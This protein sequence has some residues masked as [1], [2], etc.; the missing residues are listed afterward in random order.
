MQ[1]TLAGVARYFVGP[2]TWALPV[3][4]TG[5][6]AL[7]P[8]GDDTIHPVRITARVGRPFRAGAL[9]RVANGD[10]RLLMDIVG[11]AIA[12]ALPPDYQGRYADTVPDL[13]E[14]RRLLP[15]LWD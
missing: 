4:I 6:D 10:R 13:D 11:L 3:G 5:T 7:F 8:I 2:D 14:A 12:G 15:S 1:Q 9:R